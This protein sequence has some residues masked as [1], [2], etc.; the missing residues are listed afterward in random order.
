MRELDSRLISLR[1]WAGQKGLELPS[2]PVFC[3][4]RPK[5][6]FELSNQPPLLFYP[7]HPAKEVQSEDADCYNPENCGHQG[8]LNHAEFLS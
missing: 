2:L 3:V 8:G 4:R 1:G 6:F 7:P 5:S